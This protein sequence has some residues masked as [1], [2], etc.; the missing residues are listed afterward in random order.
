MGAE[1]TMHATWAERYAMRR[2]AVLALLERQP[3]LTV[4]EIR[5]EL[6]HDVPGGLTCSWP[7][8]DL[9]RLQAER[10]AESI[11]LNARTV[12]WRARQALAMPLGWE[13]DDG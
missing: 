4:R 1:P 13:G 12:L 8:H 9:C 5:D 11:H 7:Y 3:N 10:K 6:G 2:E